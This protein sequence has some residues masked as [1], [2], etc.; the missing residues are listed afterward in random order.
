MEN[1]P[2]KCQ[3]RRYDNSLCGRLL[4][5]KKHCIYHSEDVKRKK[6]EFEDAFLKEFERQRKEDKKYD[7]SGFIFPGYISFKNIKFDKPTY[8]DRVIFS[9]KETSFWGAQFSGEDTSFF[10]TKFSGEE[11]N[12]SEAQFSGEDT[13]F[14]EAKFSGKHT[15][16]DGTQF[17]SEYTSFSG[18]QF[19]GENTYFHGAQ[20]SSK[21][22]S[23]DKAQ[24]SCKGTSFLFTQFLANV[25]SFSETQ[26]SSE[27]TSFNVV[28]FS[29]KETVFFKTQFSG[30]ETSFFGAIFSGKRTI[31]NS[32]KF[33]G[34]IASFIEA[35]FS[36]KWIDFCNSY[37]K[38]VWYLFE[39]L[40]N[41]LRKEGI[42]RIWKRKYKISDFRFFLGEETAKR[43]P[44]IDR[45]MK[46]AWYLNDYKEQHPFFYIIWNISS[47][48][49]QKISYWVGWSLLFATFF[50]LKFYLIYLSFPCL[51]HFNPAIKTHSFWSFVYYSFVTF[52]TLGF[53][54]II[55]TV[56]WVQG[57]VIAEVVLGYIMLGGL[58]S[59]FANKLARRS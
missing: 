21:Y 23:F 10:G 28:Q 42:S 13:S 43:H 51:F 59:I 3:A 17:S 39:V 30:K 5:D 26:F 27:K 48:C 50:A 6:K 46:D 34:E 25:T 11:T 14:N 58:I 31:F 16:F 12:F 22:V 29:G 4:Y 54:D 53:G 19:S 49:G 52:T 56:D 18:A 37:L 38:N 2:K 57:W 8:F 1:E 55:P 35:Q 41:T 9:G 20:F 36:G 32:V 7:F 47:K 45:M 24:F 40:R 15:F 33:S 44:V